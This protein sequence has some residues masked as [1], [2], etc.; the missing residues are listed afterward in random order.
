MHLAFFR[1]VSCIAYLKEFI[2]QLPN[3]LEEVRANVL[4]FLRCQTS[5][6]NGIFLFF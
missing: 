1:E 6:P 5:G 4:G 2:D 3:F